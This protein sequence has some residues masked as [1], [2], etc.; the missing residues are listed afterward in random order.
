MPESAAGDSAAAATQ[1]SWST[2][3]LTDASLVSNARASCSRSHVADG[4]DASTQASRRMILPLRRTQRPPPSCPFCIGASHSPWPYPGW[5]SPY[6]VS[7][8]CVSP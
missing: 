5:N 7:P 6:G 4:V 2:N 8:Y 3:G 1:V